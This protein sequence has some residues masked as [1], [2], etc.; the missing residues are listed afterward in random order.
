[1]VNLLDNPPHLVTVEPMTTTVDSASGNDVAYYL[2]AVSVRCSVQPMT[3]AEVTAWGLTGRTAYSVRCR[4]WP[5]NLGARVT[6][7]GHQWRQEGDTLHRTM[8]ARTAHDSAVI[9][10]WGRA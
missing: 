10:T 9:V 1:M 5:G 6:W 2:P 4:S 7:N 8:S 3:T